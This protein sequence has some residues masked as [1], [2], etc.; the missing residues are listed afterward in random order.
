MALL[1]GTLLRGSISAN[2]PLNSAPPTLPGPGT[3]PV[4]VPFSGTGQERG[5]GRE[6]GPGGSG[7]ARGGQGG[8]GGAREDQVARAPELEQ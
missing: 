8:P 7:G 4:L 1:K 5:Q 6:G 2:V 3:G